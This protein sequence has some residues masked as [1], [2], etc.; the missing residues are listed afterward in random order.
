MRQLPQYFA[1]GFPLDL[2]PVGA[3]HE[4]AQDGIGEHIVTDAGIPLFCGQLTD[5]QGRSLSVTIVHDFQQIVAMR[6][7]QRLQPPVVDDQQLHLGQLLELFVV[8]AVGLSLDQL[9]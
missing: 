2:E 4:A 6:R 3:M 1:H 5:Y 8:T 7:L 9:Q